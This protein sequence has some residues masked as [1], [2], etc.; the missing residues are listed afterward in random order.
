MT[1]ISLYE[2]SAV[3]IGGRKYNAMGMLSSNGTGNFIK[4]AR[5][6]ELNSRVVAMKPINLHSFC[7]VKV[8]QYASESIQERYGYMKN[9]S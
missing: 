5:G 9:L 1:G 6:R 7:R 3:R 8:C 2:K 4:V